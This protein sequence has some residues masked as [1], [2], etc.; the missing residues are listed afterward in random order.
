[1]KHLSG[2][3]NKVKCSTLSQNWAGERGQHSQRQGPTWSG[4][5]R[6]HNLK[7]KSLVG[8]TLFR[9]LSAMEWK[10][11]L[12]ALCR[13][14]KTMNK[15]TASAM[16]FVF[17]ILFLLGLP[18]GRLHPSPHMLSWGHVTMLWNS[19]TLATWRKSW[20]I[21]KDSDAGKDLRLEEKWSVEDETVGWY[22]RL[23]G[24]EFEWTPGVG[25]G[26]PGML[27]FM[28]LQSRTRQSNWT[29]LNWLCSRQQ[30][31]DINDICPFRP[32]N[33]SPCGP[34]QPVPHLRWQ[35]RLILMMPYVL[36]LWSCC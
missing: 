22:H 18:A 32:C 2:V 24:P 15:S 14:S 16:P 5:S 8:P 10:E 6:Q 33:K 9:K 23:D 26:Q 7:N 21:W 19:N 36:V 27:R 13:N 25:D 35:Q 28:A 3:W 1:M 17:Q 12:S 31:A 11:A 34:S 29:E 20:L 4:H 30:E